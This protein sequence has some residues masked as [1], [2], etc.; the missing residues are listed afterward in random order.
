MGEEIFAIDVY[1][2]SAPNASIIAREKFSIFSFR[3]RKSIEL[4]GIDRSSKD[5]KYFR[6]REL[7]SSRV[8]IVLRESL[9]DLVDN[10]APHNILKF[11]IQCNSALQGNRRNHDVSS[12]PRLG[13]DAMTTIV[14][15]RSR[16]L[17]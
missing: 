15:C 5:D 4:R 14:V 6:I 12:I 10:D 7:N 9:D 13:G 3:N 11:K 8:Q 17:C 16:S 1:P 2:R